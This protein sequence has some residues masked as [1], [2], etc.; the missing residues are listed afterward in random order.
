MFEFFSLPHRVDDMDRSVSES[1]SK[2]KQDTD[3]LYQ[4]VSFLHQQNQQLQEHNSVLKRLVEE[5]KLTMHEFRV[6]LMHLPKTPAEIKQ[7]VEQHVNVEPLLQRIRH[8]EQKIEALE[9]RRERFHPLEHPRPSVSDV[10]LQTQKIE[11]KPASTALREKLMRKIARNSKDY[12]KNL[13]LGLVHKYGRMGALQLRDIVVEEQGLCSKSSFY[14][15]LEEME[16][17]QGLQV[18][19]DGKHTIYVA[20]AQHHT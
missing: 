4:W 1:F 3:A 6:T 15:I 13:V 10:Q 17:E 5:Q 16:Q 9:L 2:V 8:I 19:S 7:L 14:R 11:D 20:T 12:I 18:V